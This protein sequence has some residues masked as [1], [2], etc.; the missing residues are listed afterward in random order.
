[1]IDGYA[2][3]LQGEQHLD[4]VGVAGNAQVEV[5]HAEEHQVAKH[6]HEGDQ[7]AFAGGGQIRDYK[8]VPEAND[9]TNSPWMHQEHGA[10]AQGQGNEAVQTVEP[11]DD[12]NHNNAQC[13]GHQLPLAL[14]RD[15]PHIAPGADAGQQADH[16][17]HVVE[18]HRAVDTTSLLLIRRYA[19]LLIYIMLFY[20][21]NFF[22]VT[23]W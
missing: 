15:L 18:T 3:H 8:W 22:S 23:R 9:V 17:D 4:H 12:H 7:V 10:G 16:V 19:M 21:Y 5:E 13:G 11:R 20:Y 1:M 2:T 14:V 6:D